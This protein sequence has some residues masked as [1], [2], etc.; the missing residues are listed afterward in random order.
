MDW[1]S[2]DCGQGDRASKTI[3]FRLLDMFLVHAGGHIDDSSQFH[4]SELSCSILPA[5]PSQARSHTI[6]ASGGWAMRV[7]S[8]EFS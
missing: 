7:V 1:G 4:A 8:S 3:S 6:P 5:S 2:G